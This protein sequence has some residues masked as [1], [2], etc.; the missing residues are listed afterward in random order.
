[1]TK[2][3]LSFSLLFAFSSGAYAAA[4]N[5][6]EKIREACNSAGFMPGEASTNKGLVKNCLSV[7]M[8]GG[9]VPGIT[10]SNEDIQACKDNRAAKRARSKK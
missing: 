3:I 4:K 5:P 9:S 8:K 2:I 1:M 6:C 10:A 7:L